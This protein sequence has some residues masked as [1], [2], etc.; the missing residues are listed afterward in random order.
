[1]AIGHDQREKVYLCA[2][3]AALAI[4]REGVAVIDHP[5]DGADVPRGRAQKFAG[6]ATIEA[7]PAASQAPREKLSCTLSGRVDEG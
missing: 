7:R 6:H 5:A 1:V 4:K 2:M 3:P